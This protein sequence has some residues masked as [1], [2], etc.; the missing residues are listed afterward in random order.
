MDVKQQICFE[1]SKVIQAWG[2][3]ATI[4]RDKILLNEA[5]KKNNPGWDG[6]IIDPSHSQIL[7][8]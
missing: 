8:K 5:K 4:T 1:I 2:I 7:R 3:V 6:L